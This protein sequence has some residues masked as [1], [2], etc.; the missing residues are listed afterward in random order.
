MAEI[1]KINN[2]YFVEYYGNGLLF[3]KQAGRDRLQAEAVKEA[4]ERSLSETAVPDSI[5]N[6]VMADFH[7]QFLVYVSACHTPRTAGRFSSE[8]T[9]FKKFLEDHGRDVKYVRD[10]TPKVLVDYYQFLV[11]TKKVNEHEYNLSKIL[12]SE[13][14]SYSIGR[15][16]V[17]DSPLLHIAF[18]QAPRARAIPFL[19]PEQASR[20]LDHGRTPYSLMVE[21]MI[22]TGIRI[23]EMVGLPRES[24]DW[25][26]RRLSVPTLTGDQSSQIRR[27]PLE[28]ALLQ[29]LR[30]LNS[31]EDHKTG[32]IF[33]KEGGTP[34]SENE[35][36]ESFAKIGRQN[37]ASLKINESILRNTFIHYLARKGVPLIGIYRYLGFTDILRMVFYVPWVSEAHEQV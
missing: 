6:A 3:R 18:K 23:R 10:L 4:I 5:R 36:R 35:V 12:L 24:V 7:Q 26:E 1:I 13:F 28:Q 37:A 30:E 22:K 15:G 14:F 2:C 19:L 25:T 34:Y 20:I 32:L 33:E 11:H 31:R 9:R 16:A 27:I 29:S 21:L 8:L 17:N